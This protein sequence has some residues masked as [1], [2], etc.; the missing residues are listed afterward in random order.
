MSA[1][2]VQRV[3][4]VQAVPMDHWRFEHALG[5]DVTYRLDIDPLWCE[6]APP[7]WEYKPMIEVGPTVLVGPTAVEVLCPHPMTGRITLIA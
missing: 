4:F 7:D 1:Q 2:A 6:E 3:T 5:R